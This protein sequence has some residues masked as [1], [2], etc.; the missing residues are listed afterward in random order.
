MLLSEYA[1]HG[2]GRRAEQKPDDP[3]RGQTFFCKDNAAN[4][5]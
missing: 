3:H 5:G 1:D 4:G 2:N